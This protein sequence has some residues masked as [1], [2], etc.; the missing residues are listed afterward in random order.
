MVSV[1]VSPVIRPPIQTP[2]RFGGIDQDRPRTD[3]RALVVE[4]RGLSRRDA[5]RRPVEPQAEA[6]LDRCHGSADGGRAIAQLR[7]RAV[8]LDVQPPAH[9]HLVGR[10]RGVRADD[11]RIG[12]GLAAQGV[13]RFGRRDAETFALAG[14]EAPEPRVPA[15]LRALLVDDRPFL[16]REPVPRQEVAI[17]AAAEEA[18]LLALDA[19]RGLEPGARGL[20]P[21]LVLALLAEREPESV[22]EARIDPGE[23][24][25]LIL[26]IVCRA[27]EKQPPVAFDDARV[28]ARREPSRAGA[29]GEGQ[30][31]GKPE[32]PVAADARVRGLAGRVPAHERL[33]HSRA[34][35]LAQVERHVRDS[36]PVAGPAGGD[37][38]LGRAAGALGIGPLRVEPEAQGD[39]DRVSTRAQQGDRAVDAAAHRD[40]HPA[41]PRGRMENGAQGVRE[42]VDRELVAAHRRR[43]EQR[44]SLERPLETVGLRAHDPIAL[45]GQA[46]VRPAA[47][48]RGIANGFDHSLRLA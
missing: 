11:D 35:L 38:G 24:V 30:Q 5:V 40:R 14:R 37:H 22:E 10:E 39:A 8:E 27:R 26:P 31:L 33:D 28:V 46:D 43:L 44:Q 45:H 47:A 20:G 34:E 48:A 19:A 2:D 16:C 9:G 21:R 29:L 36:E 42:R 1:I 4:H 41:G 7:L 17:V 18:G 6:A 32:A 25:R 13:K 3:D 12:R 23:H 15:E